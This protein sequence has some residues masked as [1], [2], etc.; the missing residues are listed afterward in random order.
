MSC[1]PVLFSYLTAENSRFFMHSQIKIKTIDNINLSGNLFEVL[2]PKGLVVFLHMMPA[3]KNSY[4]ISAEKLQKEGYAGIAIDFRG[5]G[6]SQDGPEGYLKF[7][8]K[9]HQEKIKDVKAA[10]D[11]IFEKY[12][13]D[14][15]PVFLIGASI[16]ANLSIQ[17]AS[18][19]ERIKKIVLLSPGLN[20]RGINAKI[21]STKIKNGTK[22]LLVGSENDNYSVENIEELSGLFPNGVK[23][24]KII[25][26][27]AGHGT[28]MCQGHPELIDK[29]VDFI[30][31]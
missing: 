12:S 7:N 2:S 8:D 13:S 11:F 1:F 25:F 30:K 3:T 22:V 26:K 5:H 4:N 21:F 24:E 15:L 6:E 31:L 19:D 23:K 10:T 14:K 9:Q 29:I 17:E 18:E 27:D 20:Y 28:T 16:G